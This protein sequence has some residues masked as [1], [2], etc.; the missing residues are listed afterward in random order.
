MDIDASEP[1]NSRHQGTAPTNDQ[2]YLTR[3]PPDSDW[4]QEEDWTVEAITDHYIPQ[5]GP[6]WCA[7]QLGQQYPSANGHFLGIR[8]SCVILE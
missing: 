3:T 2:F 8:Y 1:S 5:T 7:A 4:D 6:K